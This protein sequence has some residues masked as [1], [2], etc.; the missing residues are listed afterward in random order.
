[1]MKYSIYKLFSRDMAYSISN[2]KYKYVFLFSI[3]AILSLMTSIQLDS[4]GSNSVGIFYSLLKDNGYIY[5]LSDYQVPFNWVFIQFLVLFLIGDFLFQDLDNNRT[6]LLLRCRSRGRYIFSKMCWIV[7]Q[8]IVLY[9]VIF[10]VIYIVSS[11]TIGDFSVG[12][13]PYFEN[14]IASQMDIQ[15]TPVQFIA[16]ILLGYIMTSI[17]LSSILL[18]GIQFISPVIT[19]FGVIILSGVSTF[20]DLKWL[21]A[22]HSMIL[23]QAIFDYEHYL[24]LRF[25]IMYSVVLYFLVSIVTFIVSRKKDI[26]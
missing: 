9:I 20:S 7:V 3:V 5:Q 11:M 18:L 1:M 23:K 4:Y 17:V 25:S 21:P 13:S 12:S 6:Y 14:A 16:R 22:I 15:I 26:L 24:T 10:A 19:Y 2:G 8:N